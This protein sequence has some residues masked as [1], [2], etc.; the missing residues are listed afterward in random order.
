MSRSRLGTG[1]DTLFGILTAT[2]R[3]KKCRPKLRRSPQL[4]F[5]ERRALRPQSTSLPPALPSWGI[6]KK[7]TMLRPTTK[8]TVPAIAARGGISDA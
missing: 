2:G 8:F 4:E 3:H 7:E 5:L 6:P 1:F